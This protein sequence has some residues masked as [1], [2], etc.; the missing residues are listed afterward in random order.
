MISVL[1][2]ALNVFDFGLSRQNAVSSPQSLASGFPEQQIERLFSKSEYL[3][4]MINCN[5]YVSDHC[6]GF[7]EVDI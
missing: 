6:C 2:Y 7:A 5:V 1:S 4:N 3:T